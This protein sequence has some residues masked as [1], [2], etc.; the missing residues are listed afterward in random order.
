MVAADTHVSSS[1]RRLASLQHAVS[2]RVGGAACLAA[3]LLVVALFLVRSCT[4]AEDSQLRPC[5]SSA[6]SANMPPPAVL[7]KMLVMVTF[8]WDINHLAFLTQVRTPTK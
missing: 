2:D 4:Q 8:Y 1:R 6:G 3:A 5:K 7:A